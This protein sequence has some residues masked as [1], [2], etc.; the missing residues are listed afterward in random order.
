MN[1]L[2]KLKKIFEN[3]LIDFESIKEQLPEITE[4][5]L[6]GELHKLYREGY[7]D[8]PKPGKYRLI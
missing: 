8:L 1:T 7:I 2:K 6:E 3:D 5:E 4:E